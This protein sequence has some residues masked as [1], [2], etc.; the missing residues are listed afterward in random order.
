MTE[1]LAL[2]TFLLYFN[3]FSGQNKPECDH[4][5]DNPKRKCKHCG[6]SV[7]A[8]KNDPDKQL[9]CDE[10]DNAYHLQCLNPPLDAIPDVDDWWVLHFTA[11]YCLNTYYIH[12][13]S[14]SLS[15]LQIRK[16]SMY[17][18]RSGWF[19]FPI[20]TF[21]KLLD[22]Y[23]LTSLIFTTDTVVIKWLNFALYT[24]QMTL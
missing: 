11:L 23:I 3:F 10:C 24:G 21:Q 4:C 16:S 5:K 20:Y 12:N 8:G 14:M 7:C 22:K 1:W 2:T 13:I 18:P 6:C 9:M 19:F 15:D 17:D